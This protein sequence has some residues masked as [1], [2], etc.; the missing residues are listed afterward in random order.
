MRGGPGD[1]SRRASERA[2]RTARRPHLANRR[3]SRRHVDPRARRGCARA[4]PIDH[5]PQPRPCRASRLPRPALAAMDA[6]GSGRGRPRRGLARRVDA[7]GALESGAAAPGPRA[8]RAGHLGHGGRLSRRPRRCARHA[9]PR[10][11]RLDG[12]R[13]RPPR[14]LGARRRARTAPGRRG[15]GVLDRPRMAPHLDPRP[16]LPRGAAPPPL[17]RPRRANRRGRARRPA[18]RPRRVVTRRARHRH[19]RPGRP[20]RP[21]RRDGAP[22]SPPPAHRGELERLAARRRRLPGR[23]LARGPP[24]RPR[25]DPE[26]PARRAPSTRPSDSP[27]PAAAAR[28]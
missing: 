11:H 17:A 19:A 16:R 20:R 1:N 8:P 9:P 4:A 26:T 10:R 15:L 6:G 23:R 18:P 21:A 28:D 22:P 12:A 13:T 2:V 27:E 5:G 14:A 25:P 3:R 7:R 24:A